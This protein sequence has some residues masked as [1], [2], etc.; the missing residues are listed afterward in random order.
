MGGGAE[1]GGS[2]RGRGA[3]FTFV[4]PMLV[5]MLAFAVLVLI[6]GMFVLF[7]FTTMLVFFPLVFTAAAVMLGPLLCLLTVGFS[8]LLGYEQIGIAINSGYN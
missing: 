4:F 3:L 5:T 1:E 2:S 7:V 8:L 6:R